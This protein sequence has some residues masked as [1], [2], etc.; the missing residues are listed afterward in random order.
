MSGN[1]QSE[2]STP[3]HGLHVGVEHGKMNGIHEKFYIQAHVGS[4]LVR[5]K[6]RNEDFH[7]GGV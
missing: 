1:I 3:L 2:Q 6:L 7:I 5:Q 4:S